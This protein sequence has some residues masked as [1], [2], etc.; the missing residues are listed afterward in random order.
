MVEKNISATANDLANGQYKGRDE[1]QAT[2]QKLTRSIERECIV[3][4]PTLDPYF[5]SNAEFVEAFTTFVTHHHRNIARI[6]IENNEQ[7]MRE[8][9]RLISLCR[10]LS[11]N[12]SIRGV[13]QEYQG[14][15]DLFFVADQQTLL[16][17]P[18]I[19]KPDITINVADKTVAAPFIRRFDYAWQRSVPMP[20]LHTFGL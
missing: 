20:G 17:Q 12:L 14:Q 18:N 9:G 3:M 8:N 4:G 10:K 13:P 6:L 5:F 19:S 1:I 7:V 2:V 11:E 15:S 16:L